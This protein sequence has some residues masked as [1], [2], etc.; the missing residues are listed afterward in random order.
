M[1]RKDEGQVLLDELVRAARNLPPPPLSPNKGEA[2]IRRALEEAG[3]SRAHASVA[4]AWSRPAAWMTA[5]ALAIAAAALVVWRT[6][7]PRSP[8]DEGEAVTTQLATGDRV[9]RTRGADVVFV[10]VSPR[11]RL[12]EVR[13][14]EALFDVAPLGAESSFAVR[15]A[16][17]EA[18]VRG[19]VFVVARTGR[20][21]TVHV[22]EGRVEVREAGRRVVLDAGQ[23]YTSGRGTI[24]ASEPLA[25]QAEG[26]R[27]ARERERAS[28]REEVRDQSAST[29]AQG[30]DVEAARSADEPSGVAPVGSSVSTTAGDVDAVRPTN[31]PRGE[32]EARDT[33]RDEESAAEDVIEDEDAIGVASARRATLAARRPMR[34]QLDPSVQPDFDALFARG[35]FSEALE[36]AQA[37]LREQPRDAAARFAEA[38]ALQGLG[39]FDAAA[40]AFDAIARDGT[41]ETRAE[42]AFRAASLRLHRL[43]DSRGCLASLDGADLE[44][45]PFAERALGL[46]ARCSEA[47]GD[48]DGARRAAER[49]LARFPRG[50]LHEAM[51]AVVQRAD[52]RS[53]SR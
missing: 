19:T 32:A 31:P 41:L 5:G 22:F 35:A 47:L 7:E 21:T 3:R 15:T 12:V 24:P 23:R 43:G 38:R 28:E 6:S 50:G 51:E 34:E 4:L 48:F 37:R 10:E 14:G 29:Q 45:S 33:H 26:E 53:A 36:L 13:E 20:N 40:T 30:R 49:Y 27:A 18:R 8:A 1:T 46:R 44:T 16:E 52:A 25:L 39:R 11:S 17:L 2:Q 42:A 9:V